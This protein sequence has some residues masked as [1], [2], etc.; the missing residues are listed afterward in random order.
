MASPSQEAAPKQRTS[1]TAAEDAEEATTIDSKKNATLIELARNMCDKTAKFV[2]GEMKA[3]CDSYAMLEE[4]NRAATK[5][6]EEQALLV[7]GI[8]ESISQVNEIR[9]FFFT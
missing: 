7:D 5:K 6:Y 9:M 8:T 3:G 1:S 4:M 2:E